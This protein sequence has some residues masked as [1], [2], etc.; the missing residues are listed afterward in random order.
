MQLILE[1]GIDFCVSGFDAD[2]AGITFTCCRTHSWQSIPERRLETLRC[3]CWLQFIFMLISGTLLAADSIS[4]RISHLVRLHRRWTGIE[5]SAS[6]GAEATTGLVSSIPSSR[7][8]VTCL[9]CCVVF[10]RF[11]LGFGLW[12]F[13]A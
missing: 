7:M 10:L 11:A 4:G 8:V 9:L 5:H 3:C 12:A 2:E 1:V 6:L 13:G